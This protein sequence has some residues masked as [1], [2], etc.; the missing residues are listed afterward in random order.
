MGLQACAGLPDAMRQIGRDDWLLS[1]QFASSSTPAVSVK[2]LM[3]LDLEVGNK[4]GCNLTVRA[5]EPGYVASIHYSGDEFNTSGPQAAC[6]PLVRERTKHADHMRLP[7]GYSLARGRTADL[8]A[9]PGRLVG[10]ARRALG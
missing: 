5:R 3:D 9:R 1:Y 6:A 10:L 4:G 8:Q 2:V 7:D